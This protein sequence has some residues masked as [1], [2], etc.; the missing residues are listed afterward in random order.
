LLCY[1]CGSY[2]PDDSRKCAVC[3]QPIASRRR[4][5]RNLVGGTSGQLKAIPPLNPGEV[6]G[7]RYRITEPVGTGTTGWL[8][9]ARDEEVDV[10]VA[11]KL[12]AANLLQTEDE[13]S[14]FLKAVKVAKKIH[15]TNVVRLYD[16][17]RG[18]RN[19][20]YTMPFL[21]G[22]SLRR[23]IDLRVEKEQVFSLSEA[24]PLIGQLA[25]AIDAMEKMGGHGALRPS[26]IMV[27]P[28]VLKVTALPHFRGLPRKPFVA[29]QSRAGAIEYLA[30]EARRGEEI[31]DR[32]ADIYSAAVIFG[33]MV[34]GVV[35]GRA[36]EAWEQAEARLP[37]GVAAAIHRA[38]SDNAGD[39]F[40]TASE[41]FEVLAEASA[42]SGGQGSLE[43]VSEESPIDSMPGAAPML[44][45]FTDGE[46]AT[47]AV[48]TQD[49]LAKGVTSSPEPA[50]SVPLDPMQREISVLG[51]RRQERRPITLKPHE[52][53]G[54]RRQQPFVGWLAATILLAGIAV[55]AAIYY[56]QRPTSPEFRPV[57]ETPVGVPD[58]STRPSTTPRPTTADDKGVRAPEKAPDRTL[59][60]PVVPDKAPDR[61]DD[62]RP[63]QEKGK[64]PRA[65]EP[66]QLESRL[67][68]LKNKL[69]TEDKTPEPV[70]APE[71]PPPPPTV[72]V[73]AL[74]TPAPAVATGPQ[75]LPGMVAID[76]GGFEMG[77][78]SSD[79][80]RGFGELASVKRDVDS[81]CID[82]YEFPNQKGRAPL[83]NISWNNARKACQKVGKRL[84]TEPEWEKACKG[85]SGSLFPFGGKF[86]P[87]YCNIAEAEGE[88]RRLVEAGVFG[89]CRSGY[90]VVDMTGNAAEWTSSQ[91]AKDVP[92]RVIKG[93]AA[94]QG[95][96][97][98][99]C[100]ARGN[101][102]A[103]GRQPKLG[104]R[105]CV[106]A[107]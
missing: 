100:A 63:V 52:R 84:C 85:P 28:D 5:S 11:V 59:V 16:A 8:F 51:G 54:S 7:D 42:A 27:L 19:I 31:A 90:G 6:I 18:E 36:P 60:K 9:R 61:S 72:V 57:P 64:P 99:R 44:S 29:L 39:R 10:D 89:R 104:F 91:F 34:T 68:H 50:P 97:M 55:S 107:K 82:I 95:A 76:A 58:K 83:V 15:H 24:L 69:A 35:Y 47:P 26:N 87:A 3:G 32:R 102:A 30:P 65:L 70:K 2:T 88:D 66:T 4:T 77:S 49:L 103:N 25:L 86:D 75:C 45:E 101:E 74:A 21:E 53:R 40:E 96:Y 56:R 20:Y 105:C 43:L 93:G 67:G 12:I 1:R 80:M 73:P 41:L 48:L 38:L 81:Y 98:G 13:R 71:S 37:S 33:E 23:I 46:S 92:D 14:V 106:D 62:R 22:L 79:P 78:R 94:D 17:G